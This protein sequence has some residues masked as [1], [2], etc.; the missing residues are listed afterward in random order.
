MKY[1]DL[2]VLY[3]RIYKLK[4]LKRKGWVER[5][6][7]DPESVAEHSFGVALVSLALADGNEGI[8]LGKLLTMALIHDLAESIIGDLTPAD[9]VD[10]EEKSRIELNATKEVLGSFAGE[11]VFLELWKDF[12]LGRSIEG[13]LV[14]D[15]DRLEMAFQAR[16]YEKAHGVILDDFYSY[17]AERLATEEAK[18]MLA[19]LLKG[20]D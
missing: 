3:D 4:T 20:R 14:K 2:E 12:E 13:L 9:G 1:I 15:A 6:V 5:S 8:D 16:M 19:K 17:V 10:P 18:T 7:P 11:E